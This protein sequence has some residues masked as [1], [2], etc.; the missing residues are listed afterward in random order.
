METQKWSALEGS[1]EDHVGN[2]NFNIAHTLLWGQAE[3][4]T[5]VG[6]FQ[7]N[8]QVQIKNISYSCDK[9]MY[10]AINIYSTITKGPFDL[11]T[12]F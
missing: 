9:N 11:N 8:T 7:Q 10:V 4:G 6:R 1:R 2:N 3:A 12:A 5:N